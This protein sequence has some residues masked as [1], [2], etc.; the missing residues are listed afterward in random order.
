[1]QNEVK[2]VLLPP[3]GTKENYIRIYYNSRINDVVVIWFLFL[4]NGLYP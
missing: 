1:M 2:S 4:A 3:Y